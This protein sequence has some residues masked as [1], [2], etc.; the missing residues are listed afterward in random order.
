MIRKII[1]K[2]FIKFILLNLFVSDSVFAFLLITIL[3]VLCE[4]Q[5]VDL[6]IKLLLGILVLI[7]LLL[8]FP[9][10]IIYYKTAYK[11]NKNPLICMLFNSLQKSVS[12][13]I[14]FLSL[15]NLPYIII[16]LLN[17]FTEHNWYES[18]IEQSFI[19]VIMMS[20]FLP[21]ICLFAYLDVEEFINVYS[22]Q[23]LCRTIIIKNKKILVILTI[24]FI[25]FSICIFSNVGC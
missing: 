14:K 4:T 5:K 23:K 2:D 7:I 19:Y 16:I 20:C 12:F 10:L 8:K 1:D 24:F 11:G 17:S 9:S 25:L 13:R 15:V 3:F 6:I 22:L 21:Y 18:I